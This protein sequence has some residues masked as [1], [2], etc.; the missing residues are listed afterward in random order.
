MRFIHIGDVH[1]GMVPDKGK[2]W[3]EDGK[4]MIQDSLPQII[5]ICNLKKIDLLLIAGDLFHRQPLLKD[6]KEVNYLFSKL[7][8]TKVVLIAGNHDYISEGSHYNT[9][10]WCPQTF[11]LKNNKLERVCFPE[12]N[13]EV[14]GFSYDKRDIV[15]YKYTNAFPEKNDRIQ[16]L[17]AHGGDSK[18]I[19]IDKNNLI[20]LG[21]DYIALGHIH[22]KERISTNAAYCGSLIP[23]DR[24]ETGEHGYILGEI[25]QSDYSIQFI[26]FAQRQY[27]PITLEAHPGITAGELLDMAVKVVKSTPPKKQ[28]IFKFTIAGRH[29]DDLTVETDRLYNIGHVIEVI[30]ES[31]LDYDFD[32][33]YFENKNNIIGKYIDRV[34]NLE[35]TEEIVNKALYYGMEALFRA[36]E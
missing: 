33:L 11:M 21:Y 32:A 36:K 3:S 15:E 30:D 6:L 31:V 26:P 5:E 1:L 8:H 29:D 19:P 9:F 34:R 2:P 35:E 25:G 23:L 16:I 20:N 18:N 28:N 24:N 17:L 27:Y 7:T 14:Y 22:K 4:R 12:L 13:T 10:N